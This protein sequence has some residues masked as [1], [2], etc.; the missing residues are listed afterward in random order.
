MSA[1]VSSMMIQAP[2][3]LQPPPPPLA[4]PE[5]TM[6]DMMLLVNDLRRLVLDMHY[7]T[8]Q[9]LEAA[10][11]ERGALHSAINELHRENASLKG[12]VAHV[13]NRLRVV[14]EFLGSAQA[15]REIIR[16][17]MKEGLEEL[18]QQGRDLK[19]SVVK[20]QGPSSKLA[21][22]R[23]DVTKIQGSVG[24][25]TT[26]GGL[27]EL[28]QQGRDLK[29][30]VVKMQGPSSKL[31]EIRRDVTKIQGSVGQIT[32]I[33][34]D[35]KASVVKMQGPSS[36]LAEIRRDVTKVQSSVGQ[37]T[38]VV[39]KTANTVDQILVKA[40]KEEVDSDEREATHKS[41]LLA[42][43]LLGSNSY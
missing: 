11:H 23:R 4:Q 8:H 5:P 6:S 40:G 21:E 24:Q 41:Y 32:T 33:G 36:K 19:A 39:R 27:E 12:R 16:S 25:I 7:Q 28:G 9:Q 10:R 18:G 29:A 42:G 38:T 30:S 22:I 2:P 14:S 17:E 15:D 1:P 3:H 34:K 37:M 13:D 20:M 26:I 31:A 43:M 35:L